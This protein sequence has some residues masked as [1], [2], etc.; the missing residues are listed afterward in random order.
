[1]LSEIPPIVPIRLKIETN[2]REHFDVYGIVDKKFAIRSPWFQGEADIKTFTP[3]E[4]LGTKLR[5]L[6]QRRKGRDLF[7]FWVGLNLKGIK[8][9]RIVDVFKKYIAH[10]NHQ[11]TRAEFESNL[12]TKLKT[13][14]FLADLEPL[15]VPDLKYDPTKTARKVIE[16]LVS[17]L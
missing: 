1:M 5:A 7:D 16:E 13:P 2:S 15:L 4:L 14:A 17:L 11:V 6:Y 9:K 3:E 10:G 12:T 8:P